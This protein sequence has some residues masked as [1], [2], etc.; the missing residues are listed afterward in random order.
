MERS[1]VLEVARGAAWFV[2]LNAVVHFVSAALAESPL[3]TALAGAVIADLGGSHLGVRW[4]ESAEVGKPG[5]LGRAARRV[6]YGLAV[7]AIA[8]TITLAVAL[9][10]GWASV[11][12]GRP[13]WTLGLVVLRT[14]AAAVR[15]EILLTGIPFVVATR[16]RVPAPFALAFAVVAHGAG[17]AL[18]PGVS[19]TA[20][21]LAVALGGLA[22]TLWWRHGGLA[23]AVGAVAGFGVLTGA[24]LRGAGLYVTWPGSVVHPGLGASGRAAWLAAAVLA[25]VTAVVV[26]RE[27]TGAAGASGASR[28]SS[29]R[30]SG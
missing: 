25:A 9:A 27:S 3:A 13:S 12:L 15:D 7:A 19:V 24:L 14:T 1:S 4:Q 22:A 16:A 5:A 29:R 21:A 8:V 11:G 18:F 23:T 17:F 2:A 28:W 26:T 6:G 10:L 20:V 30:I